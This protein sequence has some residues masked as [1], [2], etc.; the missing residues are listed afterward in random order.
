[1]VKEFDGTQHRLKVK[2]DNGN[3]VSVKPDKKFYKNE[4]NLPILSKNGKEY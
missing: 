2:Y 1:M 4:K 3:I